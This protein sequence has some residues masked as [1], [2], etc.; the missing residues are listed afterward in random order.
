[1]EP[2]QVKPAEPWSLWLGPLGHG[3]VIASVILFLASVLL[4]A[5]K[6][7]KWGYR[8]FFAGGIGIFLVFAVLATLFITE[9]FQYEYV[10]GRSTADL[11][12]AFRIAAVWSGQQG[13]FLLWAL[14]SA[15]FG[16]IVAPRTGKYRPVFVAV[17]AAFLTCLAG[18][19]AYETPFNLIKEAV[20]DGKVF[21]PPVGNGLT[22]A[23]QNIWVVI[24]PPI[25]F[26]GFGAL[27][28]PF[29]WAIAAMA[30][31]D[32]KAWVPMVRPWAILG[33]S[34]LGLGLCLGGFWAYETLGWGGFWAWDPVEN[35]SFVPWVFM[36]A[37]VHG[38]IVQATRGRWQIANLI[39]ATVPFLTFCFGTL[40]TRSGV[41]GDASVHS[42]AE[43][44]RVALKILLGLLLVSLL[45]TIAML[46][47]SRKSFKSTANQAGVGID[48]ES[49][50]SAGVMLLSLIGFSTALGMSYPFFSGLISGKAAIIE[51][52]L[53][54]RTVTWFFVP[55]MLFMA[56]APFLSWRKES[57][58]SLAGK[59]SG[60]FGGALGVTGLLLIYFKQQSWIP[61]GEA[62]TVELPG[63]KVSALGWICFLAFL[64][65]FVI[66]ANLWRIIEARKQ[67]FLSL[68]GFI[69]HVGLAVTMSGLI[70]SLGLQ[71]KAQA[72]MPR[73]TPTPL[74]DHNIT[75]G[76]MTAKD[77]T[78]RNNQVLIAMQGEGSQ[79]TATPGLYYL[80]S[81]P[82]EPEKAMVWPSIK[83]QWS[84]DVYL[85]LHQPMLTWW[86]RDLEL[87]KGETKTQNDVEV[88]YV[89]RTLPKDPRASGAKF[90][91]K[92][93]IKWNGKDYDAEPYFES[94]PSQGL[95]PHLVPVGNDFQAAL[96]ALPGMSDDGKEQ[97]ARIQLYLTQPLYPIELFYKPMTLLVWVGTGILTVGGFMSAL[98]R[99]H[100]P[101][102]ADVES[103]VED[104]TV[105]TA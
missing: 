50:Y 42:F 47:A 97:P 25:I 60:C 68:G 57:F 21:R 87:K 59:L 55:T 98:Y 86:D 67:K 90:G 34:I 76:D 82:G 70:I 44:N 27:T 23:L 40:M 71:R 13:S 64:T 103:P 5:V 89:D 18:I 58:R 69:A 15:T 105:P 22:P 104:A 54:H 65:S 35:V 100:R 61:T 43:M 48:R 19:L 4:I 83:H 85:T 9:Q 20:I 6:R 38:L 99:R 26:A 30:T 12:L 10:F 14:T 7:P 8:A 93:R 24:H 78:D 37:L 32:A 11:P 94:V 45:G 73:S 74:L 46:V 63:M 41:L 88:T 33:T 1:M 2:G 56:A 95:V 28:V 77:P 31:R 72:L 101:R 96:M 92:L 80:P 84:H 29:A 62:A 3:L 66:V 16:L 36:I 79:Y 39:L 52:T 49:A 17:Y 51:A 91:V 102:A 75:V 53:Y 81:N